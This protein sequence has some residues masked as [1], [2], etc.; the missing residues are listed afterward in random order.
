MTLNKKIEKNYTA[1]LNE[2]LKKAEGCTEPIA[3]AYCA[4]VARQTL[5]ENPETA[6]ILC[7]GNV[8]KNTKA[9][10][11]PN[12]DGMVGIEAAAMAGVI[13]GE[14]ERELEVLAA[15]NATH[16]PL[17]K[18]ALRNTKITV[19]CIDN[20]HPLHIMICLSCGSQSV[21]VCLA[22]THTGIYYIEKNDEV[23]FDKTLKNKRESNLEYESLNIADILRYADTISLDKVK[24]VLMQEIECNE[25]ISFEGLKHAWGQCVGRTMMETDGESRRIRL[26]AHAAAGS[27]ARM[28]GCAMPVV[29]NSG[30]GNQGITVSCPVIQYARECGLCTEKLMRA[31]LVSNL[32]AI[33]QKRDI[34]KLSAF[35]GAVSAAIGAVCGIAYLKNAKYAEICRIITNSL[36]TIGGMVCDGAKSSCAAKI[37]VALQSAF[38]ASDLAEHCRGFQ[39]GEGL[40]K[41]DIEKTITT[42]GRMASEGMRFTDQKILELMLKK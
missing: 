4:A 11:V 10:T 9:V 1:I 29:I 41:D 42:F 36:A 28:S 20:G 17:I 37:A 40:V 23:L 2:E 32:I 15:C 31:L 14:P 13:A 21:R 27:D 26:I 19:H 18:N 16:I 39:N 7:S 35:C 3:I 22:D 33:R 24:T 6:E 25:H 30:S 34:G 8:L 5:G 38:L 12:T